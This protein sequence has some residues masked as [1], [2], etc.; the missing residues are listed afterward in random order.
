VLG[1]ELTSDAA[2]NKVERISQPLIEK[3]AGEAS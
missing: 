3:P 1:R 2:A